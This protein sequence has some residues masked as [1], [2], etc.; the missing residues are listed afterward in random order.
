MEG[1]VNEKPGTVKNQLRLVPIGMAKSSERPRHGLCLHASGEKLLVRVRRDVV[2]WP[3]HETD[4]VKVRIV[5]AELS[6]YESEFWCG[7]DR[8]SAPGVTL[9]AVIV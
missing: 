8:T 7:D 3:F 9:R 2:K 6:D 5:V 4:A 1:I